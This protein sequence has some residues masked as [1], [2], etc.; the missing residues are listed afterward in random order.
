[1]TWRRL[2]VFVEGPD[3]ER[4]VARIL[5]VAGGEKYDDIRFIHYAKQKPAKTRDLL[6]NVGRLPMTDYLF[7][8]D[9]DDGPCVTWKKE[10]LAKHFGEA[11]D[12]SK[13]FVVVPEIEAWYIAGLNTQARRALRLKGKLAST[14]NCDA[15]T[16]EQLDNAMPR[17]ASRVAFLVQMAEKFSPKAASRASPSFRYFFD[18]VD[19]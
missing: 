12:L 10:Q 8:A 3:D 9:R 15:I 19:P 11:L 5:A 7:L 2:F 16:K 18:N 6:R 13:V 17:R 4:L 1:M 14:K